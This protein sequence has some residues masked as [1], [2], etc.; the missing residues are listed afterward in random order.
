MGGAFKEVTTR[1]LG[2]GGYQSNLS[3]VLIRMGNWSTRK[4]HP[5][6]AST[7]QRPREDLIRRWSSASWRVRPQ[8]KPSLPASRCG[9]SSL[10]SWEKYT[11]IVWDAQSVVL[12]CG[13]LSKLMTSLWAAEAP[14]VRLRNVSLK[15]SCCTTPFGERGVLRGYRQAGCP[16]MKCLCLDMSE[17]LFSHWIQ[18]PGKLLMEA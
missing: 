15:S 3:G 1:L 16:H 5:R 6:C 2:E 17:G 9:L 14:L 11:S 4:R 7:E 12:C 8:E 13:C 10:R 18:Q